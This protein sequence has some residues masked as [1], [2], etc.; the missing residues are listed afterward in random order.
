MLSKVNI[1]CSISTRASRQV[2]AFL[3]Q[4]RMCHEI[5]IRLPS[6]DRVALW[7]A[8]LLLT[9]LQIVKLNSK[10][11]VA[12]INIPYHHPVGDDDK[13]GINGSY[14]A[15]LCA[16]DWGLWRTVQMNLDRLLVHISGYAL[17]ALVGA[18]VVGRAGELEAQISDEPKSRRWRVRDRVG[19]RV[20]WYEQPEEVG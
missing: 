1:G 3:E 10:D 9:K 4:F 20:Q 16:S 5:P 6:D 2:D 15:A 8:E 17:A 12:V 13:M 7:P 18:E 19:N 11:V 14:V